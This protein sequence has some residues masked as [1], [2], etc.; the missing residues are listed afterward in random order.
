MDLA[1]PS[2]SK[3][4]NKAEEKA[5]K[6]KQKTMDDTDLIDKIKE[7]PSQSLKQ[8]LLQL[9]YYNNEHIK[10]SDNQYN[11][12]YQAIR[13]K[14]EMQYIQL[15]NQIRDILKSTSSIPEIKEEEYKDYDISKDISDNSIKPIDDYW[16]TCIENA[17]FFTINEK[18]KLIL[19]YLIDVNLIQLEG[20]NFTLEFLFK[21]NDYMVNTTLQ[22]TYCFE[23]SKYILVSS[24]STE[25]QWKDESKDPSKRKKMKKVKK[26]K[27]IETHTISQNV[28]SFFDL[29][30]NEIKDEDKDETETEA[31]FIKDDLIPNSL[32]YYLNII[33][34]HD[35][36]SEE[37][38]DECKHKHCSHKH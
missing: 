29:F 35:A 17:K 33:E 21:E 26:G 6:K 11:V 23:D 30:K 34:I 28:E 22:K 36:E 15:Y 5:N 25:P 16:P 31:K 19:Q 2:Q 12:E 10:L 13:N 32:E 27:S 7:E 38:E 4:E 18:D 20:L 1:Q 14:Y 8:K 3:Q 37:D 9:N 24:T